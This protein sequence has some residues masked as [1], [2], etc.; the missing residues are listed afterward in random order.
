[1]TDLTREHEDTHLMLPWY[2]NGTLGGEELQRVRRHISTCLVCRQELAGLRRQVEFIETHDRPLTPPEHS[3][4]RLMHRIK[5]DEQ[6]QQ[7][8]GSISG[9]IANF[10][11]NG[12][13]GW[14]IRLPAWA[15]SLLVLV[16]ASGGVFVY[17]NFSASVVYRTLADAPAAS[18]SEI[19]ADSTLRVVFDG[20]LSLDD[21][22]KLL[23]E[24]HVT[25]ADGP[26]SAAAYTLQAVA[27]GAGRHHALT[28][29]RTKPAVRFAEPVMDG[30]AGG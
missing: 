14:S 25:I 17:Q 30:H 5:A 29:L 26:N 9:R 22:H 8:R 6:R 28:C 23:R 7:A 1:M 27:G 11:N 10:V 3:F 24:C 2:L 12:W 18:G 16:A 21:F 20:A 13:Q 4:A 19:T 15:L